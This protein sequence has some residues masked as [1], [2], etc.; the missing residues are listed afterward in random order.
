MKTWFYDRFI[1]KEHMLETFYRTN[2]WPA[3]SQYYKHSVSS[4]SSNNNNSEVQRRNSQL[5]TGR[6][7]RHDKCRSFILHLVFLLSTYVH[8]QMFIGL[9]YLWSLVMQRI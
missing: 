3:D 4:S 5:L 8:V 1:E 7:I 9:A 2:A 6:K